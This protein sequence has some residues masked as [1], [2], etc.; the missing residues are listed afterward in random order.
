[1]RA[2][3]NVPAGC[4]INLKFA[5]FNPIVRLLCAGGR[6]TE[7]NQEEGKTTASRSLYVMAQ[8][9]CNSQLF[10]LLSARLIIIILYLASC[11]LISFATDKKRKQVLN[12]DG[13][14]AEL[15]EEEEELLHQQKIRNLQFVCI[16]TKCY[17]FL[18][19]D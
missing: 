1:M 15:F 5:L 16:K 3:H 12:S 9:L 6:V 14:P 8:G 18:N 2:A 4:V 17:F 13:F 7:W 10:A 11:A 19:S